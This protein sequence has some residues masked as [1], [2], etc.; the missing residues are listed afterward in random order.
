MLTAARHEG[1]AGRR[2][3]GQAGAVVILRMGDSAGRKEKSGWV[4]G[5]G[6]PRGG[7]NPEKGGLTGVLLVSFTSTTSQMRG[8]STSPHMARDRPSARNR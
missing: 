6:Q 2:G 5:E 3:R 8:R 7:R 4:Q 1:R